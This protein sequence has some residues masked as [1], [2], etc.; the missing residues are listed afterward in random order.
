MAIS[1]KGDSRRIKNGLKQDD[2]IPATIDC[3][4]PEGNGQDFSKLMDLNMLA[5]TGGRERT[6]K[7]F[8]TL[9]KV[10]G[11]QLTKVIRTESHFAIVEAVPA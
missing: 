4:I 2:S 5:M 8:A 6:Q 7:E 9:L 10:G 3:V 1:R 11:F